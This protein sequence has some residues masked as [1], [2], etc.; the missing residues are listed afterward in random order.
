MTDVEHERLG[1]VLSGCRGCVFTDVVIWV[2]FP[3]KI[4]VMCRAKSVSKVAGP[5][6]AS[7][8]VSNCMRKLVTQHVTEGCVAAVQQMR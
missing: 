8:R 1:E 4:P 5:K 7:V 3:F 2:V 6:Q